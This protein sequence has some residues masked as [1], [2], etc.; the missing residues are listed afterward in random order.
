M[1]TELLDT[2]LAHGAGAVVGYTDT[3]D[4]TFAMTDAVAFWTDVRARELVSDAAA[5]FSTTPDDTTTPAVAVLQTNGA[6]RAAHGTISDA[7][8]TGDIEWETGGNG[9]VYFFPPDG[10]PAMADSVD[11]AGL[12]MELNPTAGWTYAEVGVEVCPVE[13]E[14]L[15]VQADIQ[16]AAN[17]Y[18]SA[19]VEQDNYVIVRLDEADRA[20][21]GATIL[22]QW[23]WSTVSSSFSLLSGSTLGTGWQRLNAVLVV[24]APVDWAG[25]KV[26]L[27]TGGWDAWS[28]VVGI[29]AVEVT[30]EGE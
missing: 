1:G 15:N 21:N 11:G 12:T 27:A 9:P 2:L 5:R 14:W 17:P 7:T 29:D 30:V 10:E 23:D 18:L 19:S 3:V 13:G 6:L 16:I 25:R 22:E 26:R 28:Y 24:P 8:F 20:T 4:A